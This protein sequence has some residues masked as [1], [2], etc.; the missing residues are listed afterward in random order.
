MTTAF[1]LD[2]HNAGIDGKILASLERV[3]QAFRVLLWNESKEYS[4]SPIQVQ[5]LV[6]LLHHA[7]PMR[8]VSYLAD[9]F[10]ITRA[11]ISDTIKSLERKAL[12]YKEVIQND[13]RSFVMHLTPKGMALAKRISLFANHILSPIEQMSES[14]IESFLF[15]LLNIIHYLNK[16]GIITIQRM[17]FTCQHYQHGKNKNSHYCKL[18]NTRLSEKDLRIDCPEHIMSSQ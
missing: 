11:S 9:E 12:I 4:L 3:S 16:A 2:I 8:K 15:N 5:V 7:A 10:N 13:T 18:L 14:E 17:C 6:F 1:N